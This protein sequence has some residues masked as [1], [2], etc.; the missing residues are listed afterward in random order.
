[1]GGGGGSSRVEPDD[2]QRAQAEYAL[3]LFQETSEVENQ[4]LATYAREHAGM[5]VAADGTIS[6]VATKNL[7]ADGTVRDTLQAAASQAEAELGGMQS[8]VSGIQAAMRRQDV[9]GVAG[10]AEALEVAGRQ[11]QQGQ[12]LAGLSALGTGAEA[13]AAGTNAQ[14]VDASVNEAI[15]NAGDSLRSSLGVQ[16][17]ATG[18]AGAL[19]HRMAVNAGNRR[20]ETLGSVLG[21]GA[22]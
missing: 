4:F 16:S 7:N 5:N 13:E 20:A 8:G 21:A 17:A 3:T 18:L 6:R 10:T 19:G 1:M 14:F 15:N 22:R 9:A 11:T 2:A 12:A